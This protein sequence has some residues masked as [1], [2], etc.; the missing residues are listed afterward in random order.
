[1]RLQAGLVGRDGIEDAGDAMRDIVLDDIPHKE[2]CQVDTHDRIDQIEPV[3]PGLLE[4]AGEEHHNLIDNPVEGESC[5]C[6]EETNE[7]GQ[8]ENEHPV[9][10]MLHAPLMQALEDSRFTCV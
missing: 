4:G 2:R 5:H 10:D 3:G 9:A 8:D 6:R 1:M 7:Q